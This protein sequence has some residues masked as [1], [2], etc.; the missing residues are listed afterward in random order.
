MAKLKVEL[1]HE[2]HERAGAGLRDR[3][4]ANVDRLAAVGSALAP[5]SNLVPSVPGARAVLERTVG[6]AADRSLPRFERE[7]LRD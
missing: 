7:T 1:L 2:R 5:L 3:L 4:F 6:I